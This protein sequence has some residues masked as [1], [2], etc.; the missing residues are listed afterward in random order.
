MAHL[1]KDNVHL[2]INNY[3]AD[4]CIPDLPFALT[5]AHPCHVSFKTFAD[6]LMRFGFHCKKHRRNQSAYFASIFS[7][8]DDPPRCGALLFNPPCP[9]LKQ[10]S[11]DGHQ[12]SARQ[13]PDDDHILTI[14]LI[15]WP[16]ATPPPCVNHIEQQLG[17]TAK[18]IAAAA[19]AAVMNAEGTDPPATPAGPAD[20]NDSGDDFHVMNRLQVVDWIK[21]GQVIAQQFLTPCDARLKVDI[22]LLEPDAAR[23]LSQ[24]GSYVYRYKAEPA[25][26]NATHI[27]LLAQEVKKHFPEAVVLQPDGYMAVNIQPLCLSSF[28][29]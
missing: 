18:T 27:G 1:T 2:Y 28:N 10:Q 29:Q 22:E 14:V 6:V 13:R 23:R 25:S 5:C 8:V 21:A 9:T 17:P 19:A 3:R 15:I 12:L 7:H 11:N 24:L 20:D 16:T 26:D 4:G